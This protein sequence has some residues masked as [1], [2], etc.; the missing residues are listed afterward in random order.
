MEKEESFLTMNHILSE[1]IEH[2]WSLVEKVKRLHWCCFLWRAKL[3][4]TNTLSVKQIDKCQYRAA[5]YG[6]IPAT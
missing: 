5:L 3:E 1:T 4:E 2:L 6:F